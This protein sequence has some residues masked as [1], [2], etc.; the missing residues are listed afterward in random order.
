MPASA[1]APGATTTGG[2]RVVPFR[3]TYLVATKLAGVAEVTMY[4]PELA[5]AAPVML[6][7]FWMRS[8][9]PTSGW[10]AQVPPVRVTVMTLPTAATAAVTATRPLAGW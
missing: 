2:V 3:S 8:T 7:V 6:E 4:W 10:A 9:W 5:F 1:T